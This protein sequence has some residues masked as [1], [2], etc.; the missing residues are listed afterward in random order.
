[1]DVNLSQY[2]LEPLRVDEEFVLYRARHS[3][4]HSLPSILVLAPASEHPSPV[5]VRKIEHEYSLRH[6][7]ES[8]W[9]I[10]PLTLSQRRGRP[11]LTLE[12]PGGD[13]LE[14]PLSGPME[15]AQFLRAAVGLATALGGLHGRRLIH[16][17]VKPANVLVNLA[18]GQIR[19][20]GFGIA[21]RLPRERQTPQPPETIAGT[22]AYMAPEQTG[23]MNRSID[24][25]S[26]LYALGVTLYE[27]V[28]GSLPFAAVDPMEWVHC[29]IARQ[30]LP[31]DQRV[32]HVP[33]PVSAIIMKL[34]AK[35]PEERYQTAAGLERD[36]QRCLSEW[37]TRG[38]VDEFALGDADFPDRLLMPERLYGRESHIGTLLATF[39]VV[40]AGGN[41]RLVLVSGPAGIGKSSLVN[42]LHKVLVPPQGL[43]ASGKVEH[44]KRDIPYATLAQAIRSL[45]RRLWSL[46][47]AEL[48][49]W[50]DHLHEA[51]DPNG[52][53]VLEL[54][55]E[56]KFMIGEQPSVADL[57]GHAAKVR[58]KLAFRRLISVFA[59]PDHP[60]VL[61]LD[62]LQ[63]LDTDTL[64]LLEDLLGQAE[65][66]HLL[67]VGACRDNEVD[68]AHPLTRTLATIRKA[69]AQV[70]EIVLAPLHD[71]DLAHLIADALRCE[72]QRAM[73]LARLVL[74]KTGGNPFFAN[75]FIQELVD[76]RLLI[77]DSGRGA[78]RWDLGSIRAKGFTDNVVELMVGKLSRLP[79]STQEA[80]K[81]LACL[82]N[83]AEA[84]MLAS[85]HGTSEEE[86]HSDL[87]EAL[88]QELIVHADHRYRFV[89]DRVHE[90]AY[91]LIPEERRAPTHLRI[92][93][94]LTAK[95]Q[96]EKREDIVFEIVGQLNRGSALVTSREDRLELAALNLMAGKRAKTTAAYASALTYFAAGAALLPE[97]SWERQHDLVF[98]L[99]LHRASCHFLTGRIAAAEERL[100][101]LSPRATSA[102]ER[103]AVACLLADIYFTRQRPD[104]GVAACLE[105]LGHAG[106]DF[107]M[108]PTD[109]QAQAAYDRTLS[110]VEGRSIDELADLPVMIDPASRATLDVL[111]KVIPCA[112]SMSKNL[113]TLII[114]RWPSWE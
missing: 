53:P 20:M 95:V 88:R 28:T 70:Q 26:D 8:A 30:A 45:I 78:W 6:E 35:T 105:C 77:F 72:P 90:A 87:W 106:L 63:W 64:D 62:D 29:H 81:E 19:L 42:E 7:L 98:E 93:R 39:D 100:V 4:E 73:P 103:S 67:I 68:D 41:P 33:P 52:A 43:F 38:T 50:R 11:V 99:E 101:T 32:T 65:L 107:P 109:E 51:L 75:Q 79:D 58:F 61:F 46:P 96:P 94:L 112:V 71:D 34:L 22:L 2:V 56:L 66:Q 83:S 54:I 40:V 13:T 97:D 5:A 48:R 31:P 23:R 59:R 108:P 102:V 69:G 111:A 10:R 25:R 24:A 37:E 82:G 60:L 113:L 74:E 14:K 18:T 3:S 15:T 85:V 44:L 76:E 1:V 104:L 27:M 47:E 91:S 55:P 92:G 114:G 36:L 57:P 86:L 12:D 16:K 21:S 80:A 89:H 49:T 110:R 9:A 17:D 84:S